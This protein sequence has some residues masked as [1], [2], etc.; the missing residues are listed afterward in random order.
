V[1]KITHG[2]TVS[3]ARGKIG[4][5]VFTRAR[6]GSVAKA[7]KLATYGVGPHNLLSAQHPDTTPATPPARGSLIT[8]QGVA[9]AWTELALG[10]D[11]QILGSDGVDAIW[12]DPPAVYTPLSPTV[13]IPCLLEVGAFLVPPG[14][15]AWPLSKLAFFLPLLIIE[16]STIKR[17]LF[18]SGPADANF[19]VGIYTEDGVR[20]VSLGS[21]AKGTTTQAVVANI[22]DTT[23]AAGRYFLAL[24]LDN[25]TGQV[26]RFNPF[27]GTN[28]ILGVY[29]MQN[30]FPLPANAVYAENNTR[31]YIPIIGATRAA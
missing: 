13:I 9:T 3:D 12:L 11:G 22:A 20:I 10:T 19:D 23:L 28:T 16:Q 24:A 14:F 4:D 27:S 30:A 21:T 7:L 6:G 8:G 31:S 15:Y 1:A 29:E 25:N 17:I 5:T 2:P 18:I 26:S